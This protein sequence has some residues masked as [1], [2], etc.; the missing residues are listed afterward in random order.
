M[1]RGHHF[2]LVV[3]LVGIAVIISIPSE[4]E[5]KI[6][7]R[8][9]FTVGAAAAVAGFVGFSITHGWRHRRR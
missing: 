5:R 7:A 3:M 6:A 9:Q 2:W 4:A 1:F 8:V